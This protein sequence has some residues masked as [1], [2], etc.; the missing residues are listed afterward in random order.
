MLERIP[1]PRHVTV[2]T[3]PLI[4]MRDKPVYFKMVQDQGILKGVVAHVCE[5]VI[6]EMYKKRRVD[7]EG[8][9]TMLKQLGV[10]RTVRD[11][12]TPEMRADAVEMERL[13]DLLHDPDNFVLAYAKH[14][15]YTLWTR[16]GPLVK[17]ARAE[18]VPCINP[19]ETHGLPYGL[20][21]YRADYHPM[22]S[23]PTGCPV[24]P[25]GKRRRRLP[26]RACPDPS[27]PRF[28]H[29]SGH[30][31]RGTLDVKSR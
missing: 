15:K 16:D 19:D 24:A 27:D 30:P 5:P 20:Y 18:G 3:C 21:E 10:A 12:L 22:P 31:A 25:K 7:F 11:D 8:I 6:R 9:R 1:K 13:H 29:M 17:V 26:R 4:E 28:R 2:D 14:T 23:A